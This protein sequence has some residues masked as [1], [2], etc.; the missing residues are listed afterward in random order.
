MDR[1]KTDEIAKDLDRLYSNIE[2]I[3]TAREHDKRDFTIQ[4]IKDLYQAMG[5]LRVPLGNLI[6][7]NL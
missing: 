2:N 1:K 7:E 4:E 6:I 5:K 3:L